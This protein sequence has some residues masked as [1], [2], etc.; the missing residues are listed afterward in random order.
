MV[1][2][3]I[4]QYAGEE[5][6]SEY[7]TEEAGTEIDKKKVLLLVG[8]LVVVIVLIV[9]IFSFM[10]GDSGDNGSSDD[11][12]P[13]K[14]PKVVCGD[15]ECDESENCANCVKDC[16]CKSGYECSEEKKCV[17]KEASEPTGHV[18]GDGKCDA[19]ENCFDCKDCR[20]EKGMRCLP[21]EKVCFK[22]V[23]GDGKC[24]S[25]ETPYTCCIDC[26]CVSSGEECNTDTK[27]CEPIKLSITEDRARELIESHYEFEGKTVVSMNV[28]GPWKWNDVP[29]LLVEVT[30]E[31][32][33]WPSKV[34][35]YED[36]K[37]EELPAM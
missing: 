23:C 34:G 35:V 25:P 37:V 10:G 31:D 17:K 32:Q 4:N 18:C 19:S 33:G 1:I 11:N 22:P 24:M 9:A 15:G 29:I 7:Q 28:R 36:E 30:I 5:G 8:G 27:K 26:F 3:V 13:I 20:C 12:P 6:V 14:E 16:G 2:Y 21:T